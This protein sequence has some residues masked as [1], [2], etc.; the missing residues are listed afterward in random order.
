MLFQATGSM[1]PP[2]D[3]FG[4]ARMSGFLNI[5]TDPDGIVRRV[6]LILSYGD[7]VYP[8]LALAATQALL[9]PDQTTLAAR[10]DRPLQL[11]IDGR[12]V[13]LGDRGTLGLRFRDSARLAHIPAVDVL[14]GRVAPG[15]LDGRLVFLGITAPGSGRF[16]TTPVDSRYPDVEVHASAAENLLQ[17]DSI[18]ALGYHRLA[19]VLLAI[20]LVFLTA[21]LIQT[22][23]VRWGA[24][25]SAL[26]LVAVWSLSAVLIGWWNTYLSPLLPT[27]ATAAACLAGV[28]A[29]FER[30]RLRFDLVHR[31]RAA[32][33]HRRRRQAHEFLVKSLTSLME[34]RDPSTGRHSRRTQGY[35]RLLAQRLAHTTEFHDYLTDDRIEL[36]S[37]LSPLHDIGKVGIRDAV[38]NKTSGLT[39]AEITR[40]SSIRST[41][42]RPSRR[43]SDRW[44]WTARTTKRF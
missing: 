4:S 5:G 1:C 25:G 15:V 37:L 18:A 34:I 16:V 35:S 22:V 39:A 2:T 42:T 14:G 6:P 23:G 12:P 8:A 27:L 28:F 30:Q 3:S 11:E 17:G 26:A 20:G 29:H 32:Q 36:L 9:E 7:A 43:R 33:G 40:C 13:A 21:L 10:R 31:W 19:Q 38:L 24:A 41:A 44:A